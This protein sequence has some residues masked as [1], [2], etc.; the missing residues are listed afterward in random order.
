MTSGAVNDE[1]AIE[2]Q[3]SAT[4]VAI[5]TRE[6]SASLQLSVG[7]HATALFKTSSVILG[8]PA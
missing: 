7:A 3:G 8:I 1:V 2:W 6:S 5:F 4:I